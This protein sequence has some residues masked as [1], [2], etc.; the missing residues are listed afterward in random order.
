MSVKLLNKYLQLC[1][2]LNK[3]PSIEGLKLFN[4]VFS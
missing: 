1:K 3:N 4:R 2:E